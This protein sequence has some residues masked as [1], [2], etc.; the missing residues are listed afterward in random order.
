MKGSGM[1]IGKL[2]YRKLLKETNLGMAGILTPK[3]CFNCYLSG[4]VNYLITS[5]IIIISKI[6]YT[7]NT[8]PY[9]HIVSIGLELVCNLD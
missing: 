4:T 3:R 2:N 9:I 6:P 7:Y 8:R 1:L 5:Y